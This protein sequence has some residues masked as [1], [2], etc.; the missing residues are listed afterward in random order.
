MGQRWYAV[1]ALRVS[2]VVRFCFRRW[3]NVGLASMDKRVSS[4]RTVLVEVVFFFVRE[5]RNH[6]GSG[7]PGPAWSW[8]IHRDTVYACV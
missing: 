5:A 1:S 8:P 2:G 3:W 7:G 4:D 6:P